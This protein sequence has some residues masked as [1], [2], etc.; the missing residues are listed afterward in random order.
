MA[1]GYPGRQRAQKA[2]WRGVK[3]TT[4]KNAFNPYTQ[5]KLKQL[6]DRGRAEAALNPGLMQKLPVQFRP[7]PRAAPRAPFPRRGYGR[8][9]SRYDQG[10]GFPRDPRRESRPPF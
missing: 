6:F 7:K 2:F 5:P 8:E 3:S 4:R 10:R 1:K 9:S